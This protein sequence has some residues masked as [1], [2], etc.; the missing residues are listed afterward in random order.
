MAKGN[1][2]G[3]LYLFAGGTLLFSLAWLMPSFPMLAFVGFAPF[4][5]IAV[6]NRKGKTIWN[7][8]DL[9]LLGLSVSF[10][11]GSFFAVGQLAHIL[12]QAM[13][14]TLTFLGYT[15]VRKSL[16]ARVSIITLPVFWL[17]AEYVLLKW[18]PFPVHFLADLFYIKPE[19]T[20][21]NPHT[22]YL[23]ASLWVWACNVL[24]YQAVLT[25]KKAN[26]VFISLFVLSVAVPILYSYLA[27]DVSGALTRED[28]MQLYSPAPYP[29]TG[30]GSIGEFIPRTAAWLSV[31][32][33]LFTLVKRKTIRK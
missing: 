2:I 28:M 10:F 20:A 33:L 8:L 18:A 26:L 3:T 22:G 5:A 1:N 12:L 13:L 21:W 25:E 6:N 27:F 19:W 7:S 15:F 9:I 4:I 17:A 16:G 29:G 30:Y 31:L 23:G 11:A 32:I 24:L 14:C